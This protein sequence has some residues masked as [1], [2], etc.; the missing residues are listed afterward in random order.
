M[1]WEIMTRDNTS[2]QW[3]ETITPDNHSRPSLKTVTLDNHLSEAHVD[4]CMLWVI[5]VTSH[6]GCIGHESYVSQVVL[7]VW[8]ICVT[9]RVACTCIP[10]ISHVHAIC[11]TSHVACM[12]HMCHK[13]CRMYMHACYQSCPIGMSICVVMCVTCLLDMRH[14]I[15]RCLL[16]KTDAFWSRQ[17]P[18]D[19]DRCLLIKTDAFWS[20]QMPFHTTTRITRCLCVWHACVWH[21]SFMCVTW[22]V[23][24]GDMNDARQWITHV[25]HKT[26]SSTC[27]TCFVMWDMTLWCVI[28]HCDEWMSE[29]FIHHSAISHITESCPYV[30]VWHNTLTNCFHR[31]YTWSFS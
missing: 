20:R 4:A 17:M 8:V 7:H 28:L 23:D 13:S 5:S 6:M 19:Q 10:A 30:C 22:L 14:A 18:F 1:H 2:R 9:S 3:F 11:V 25:H 26:H 24:M 12:S 29:S 31:I 21:A 16:I 27:V 15:H